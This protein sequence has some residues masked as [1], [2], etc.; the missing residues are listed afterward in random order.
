VQIQVPGF[1]NDAVS[2][3]PH[4]V[5]VSFSHV[6]PDFKAEPTYPFAHSH[7]V[8]KVRLWTL[9]VGQTTQINPD[10]LLVLDGFL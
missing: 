9:L 8:I 10:I 5:Q 6:Y 4:W 3:A 2:L 7:S 1:N